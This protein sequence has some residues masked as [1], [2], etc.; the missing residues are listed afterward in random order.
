MKTIASKTRSDNIILVKL[1]PGALTKAMKH[2][3]I[4]D[5]ETNLDLVYLHNGTNGV[6]SGNS[7]EEDCQW[8]YFVSFTRQRKGPPDGKKAKDVNDCLEE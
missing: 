3:V 2:Y 4:H 1:F 7:P 5:L 6:K 8:S